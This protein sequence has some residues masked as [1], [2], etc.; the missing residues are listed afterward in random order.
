[1]WTYPRPAEKTL[2]VTRYSVSGECPACG[3]DELATYPVVSDGGWWSVVKCQGCLVS[4]S[5]EKG[6]LLGSYTPLGRPS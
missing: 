2:S 1:M 4:V 6:P 5:R 3:A